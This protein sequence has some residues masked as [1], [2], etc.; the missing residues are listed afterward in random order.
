M[1]RQSDIVRVVLAIAL[2]AGLAA[3]SDAP[4]T[5]REPAAVAANPF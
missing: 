5:G 3:F 2:L 1:K 4:R